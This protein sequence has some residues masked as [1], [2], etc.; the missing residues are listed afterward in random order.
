[1]LSL[2]LTF[3]AVHLISFTC[4]LTGR[5]GCPA[6]NLHHD[7]DDAGAVWPA[8]GVAQKLTF[9]SSKL[10]F[11]SSVLTFFS[12]KLGSISDDRPCKINHTC[13]VCTRTSRAVCLRGHATNRFVLLRGQQMY[14]IAIQ[15]QY[16]YCT[17]V[18]GRCAGRL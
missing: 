3:L 14:S 11:L 8:E 1:M 10:T 17:V 16:M 2:K 13:A 9:L 7:I 15:T 4:N 5:E 18:T 12:S 6:H